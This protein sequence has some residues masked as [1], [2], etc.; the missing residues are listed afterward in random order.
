MKKEDDSVNREEEGEKNKD[1][2][3]GR[4]E[5]EGGKKK[6]GKG[7]EEGRRSGEESRKKEE[8]IRKGESGKKIFFSFETVDLKKSDSAQIIFRKNIEIWANET[9]HSLNELLELFQARK[10]ALKL[11]DEELFTNENEILTEF[12]NKLLFFR[13]KFTSISEQNLGP[14]ENNEVF[15]GLFKEFTSFKESILRNYE[16]RINQK[17]EENLSL[18]NLNESVLNS[19]AI[20]KSLEELRKSI[21]V[22][23]SGILNPIEQRKSIESLR[24]SLRE[25]VELLNFQSIVRRVE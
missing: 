4:T 1:K 8:D 25:S 13:K 7:E 16:E 17:E 6:D 10:I 2:Y 9:S 3:C 15:E 24:E 20:R 23:K 21:E 5:D 22:E 12:E 18:N 14:T 19:N 11:G